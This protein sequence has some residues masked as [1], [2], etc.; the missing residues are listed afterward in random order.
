MKI[1]IESLLTAKTLISYGFRPQQVKDLTGVNAQR[2]SA[3]TQELRDDSIVI[4]NKGALSANKILR[5]KLLYRQF[6]L[7]MIIYKQLLQAEYDFQRIEELSP[8]YSN[9][10]SNLLIK[11]HILFSRILENDFD[12]TLEQNNLITLAECFSILKE[13]NLKTDTYL[14]RCKD[15]GIHYVI[16]ESSKQT[17]NC[18]FCHERGFE[19]ERVRT[20]TIIANII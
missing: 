19:L 5:T 17:D 7:W 12:I 18:P 3:L 4:A 13:I 15:C 9:L 1:K 8:W 11:T 20:E 10:D 16:I 14:V 2:I 6:S